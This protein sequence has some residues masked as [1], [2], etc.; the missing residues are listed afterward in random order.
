MLRLTNMAPW[1][2]EVMFIDT[3]MHFINGKGWTTYAWYS[4]AKQTPFL[5]YPPLYS[6]NRYDADWSGT[7]KDMP[8]VGT[9]NVIDTDWHSGRAIMVY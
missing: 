4:V 9:K 2:D 7:S 6:I 3:P 8:T 5:L 1:V